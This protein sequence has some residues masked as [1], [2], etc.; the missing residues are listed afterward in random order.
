MTV[1]TLGYRSTILLTIVLV[2][3]TYCK[4]QLDQSARK[5]TGEK[6]RAVEASSSRLK[7]EEIVSRLSALAAEAQ[8][9]DPPLRS[10]I[11]TQVASL[12]W[13]F[14]KLFAHDLFLKA[15]DAAES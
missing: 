9:F 2:S 6:A 8:T 13:D 1:T 4:A 3:V 14:D 15:W 10:H 5:Q 7:V 12:L 11:Q